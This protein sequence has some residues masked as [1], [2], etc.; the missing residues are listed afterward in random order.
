M[1][2]CPN[3]HEAWKEVSTISRFGLFS[4]FK[5]TLKNSGTF[6]QFHHKHFAFQPASVLY[7]QHGDTNKDLWAPFGFLSHF[8]TTPCRCSCYTLATF[9]PSPQD[10]WKKLPP[11][12]RPEGFNPMSH[13]K[14][15]HFCSPQYK[16]FVVTV[17][18]FSPIRPALKWSQGWIQCHTT[19]CNI[20]VVPNTKFL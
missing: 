14:M 17:Y 12:R 5:W 4:R 2:V 20:F 18:H 7:F 6:G 3:A 9:S 10:W 11:Q 13:H 1:G 15:Q 16:V 19:K 8:F